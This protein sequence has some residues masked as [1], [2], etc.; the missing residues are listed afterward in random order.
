[1]QRYSL[2]LS[3]E[4][5]AKGDDKADGGLKLLLQPATF[6]PAVRPR[7]QR[8]FTV[9]VVSAFARQQGVA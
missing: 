7:V 4:M 1:M 9:T 5:Q 8:G 6:E 3:D 2:C